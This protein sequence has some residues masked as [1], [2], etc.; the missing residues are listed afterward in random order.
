VWYI[1][2]A[3]DGFGAW[4]AILG[5]YGSTS[6]AVPADY[7]GDH[8]TDLAVTSSD[9]VVLIDHAADGFGAWNAVYSGNGGGTFAPADYDGDGRADLA[10]KD[11]LGWWVIDDA[12]DG[13]AGWDVLV[14]VNQSTARCVANIPT[15]SI[16]RYDEVP[17]PTTL[18]TYYTDLVG[19][20]GITCSA[21]GDF[22]L[23]MSSDFQSFVYYT[24]CADNQALRDFVPAH[25]ASTIHR[26]AS[27]RSGACNACLPSAPGG[28]VYVIWT[29]GTEPDGST[30]ARC[31]SGCKL[32]TGI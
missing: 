16:T 27:R 21:P 18:K 13:Y 31:P 23:G 30:T 3:A 15:C 25:D 29:P 4:N 8:R 20:P 32:P 17:S 26:E 9:G 12:A 24:V 28:Q 2:Y 7:D 11:A 14:N 5:G 1:D 22:Q 6:I 19:R 10:T